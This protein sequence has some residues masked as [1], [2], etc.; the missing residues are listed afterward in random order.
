MT[1]FVGA[2]KRFSDF[3]SKIG[4]SSFRS[5]AKDEIEINFDI[6]EKKLNAEKISMKD[7]GLLDKNNTY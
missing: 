7:G 4:A 1:N 5:K 6:S 2:F 3:S